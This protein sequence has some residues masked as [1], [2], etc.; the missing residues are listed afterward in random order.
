MHISA[1]YMDL[2]YLIVVILQ[3]KYLANLK[4]RMAVL[5]VVPRKAEFARSRVFC[6]LTTP[7]K[8]LSINAVKPFQFSILTFQVY[9]DVEPKR[10]ALEEA[11]QE[12]ADAQETLENVKAMV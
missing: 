6:A 8:I 3:K 7:C 1:I 12:L 11:N 4:K 5:S 9:C 10:R 2:T